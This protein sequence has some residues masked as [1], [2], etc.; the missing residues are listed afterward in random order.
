M[1]DKKVVKLRKNNFFKNSIYI[2]FILLLTALIILAFSPLFN[3]TNIKVEG[4]FRLTENSIVNASD[5]KLGQNILRLNKEK[6]K[7]N[8]MQLSYIEQVN[9]RRDWP[10]KIIISIKEKKELAKI[11]TFGATLT[12][13]ENGHALESF[14]DNSIIDLPL[15][16]N[17]EVYNYGI[18]RVIETSDN[19]KINNILE[20]LKSF[21]KN[22]MLNIVDKIEEDS[23]IIIYTKFGHI[24]NLGN[25]YDLDYKIKRLKAISER[26]IS[27][28]YYF[29]ISNINIYPISKPLWT[30]TEEKQTVEV[31]E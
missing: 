17:I 23:N 3:I 2:P 30:L 15:I 7:E 21:K 6:I 19:E 22:D 24:V 29:D 10:D 9:I 31:S 26:E 4:N 12:L 28:K 18:N 8:L 1:K 25:C 27:E 14:S 11:L 13:D 16:N 20:V 5:I